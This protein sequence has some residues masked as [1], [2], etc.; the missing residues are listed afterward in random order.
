MPTPVCGFSQP[1]S[2]ATPAGHAAGQ[3]SS[4]PVCRPA[5]TPDTHTP[6]PPLKTPGRVQVV[7][8]CFRWTGWGLHD[9]VLGSVT[10]LEQLG[11]SGALYSREHGRTQGQDSGSQRERRLKSFQHL[12]GGTNR[13]AGPGRRLLAT[14]HA[15]P[16]S[17]VDGRLHPALP[18][19]SPE[20]PVTTGDGC[21]VLLTQERL[22]VWGHLLRTHP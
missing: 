22:R 1:S 16:W 4:E 20:P 7:D 21:M 19:G 8:L 12:W 10:L 14:E 2:S 5:E 15:P 3:L 17:S 11:D 18:Q 9:P 6:P 13:P